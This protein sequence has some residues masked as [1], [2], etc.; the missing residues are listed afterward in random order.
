[1]IIKVSTN[2]YKQLKLKLKKTNIELNRH[3][4]TKYMETPKRIENIN[5]SFIHLIFAYDSFYFGC[6]FHKR[7]SRKLFKIDVSWKL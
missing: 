2:F 1:M 5:V 6:V 4:K 3:N 7:P